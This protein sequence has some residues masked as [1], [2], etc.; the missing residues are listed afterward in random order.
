MIDQQSLSSKI[1]PFTLKPAETLTEAQRE[2]AIDFKDFFKFRRFESEA[3]M[4]EVLSSKLFFTTILSKQR[5]FSF[6]PESKI[7]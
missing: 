1:K 3:R 5:F 7:G 6:D 2:A 4:N